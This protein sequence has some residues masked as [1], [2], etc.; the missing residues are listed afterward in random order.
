MTLL[1]FMA[2]P[3][4]PTSLDADV[5][6]FLARIPA[7]NDR[8]GCF[9]LWFAFEQT[10]PEPVSPEEFDDAARKTGRTVEVYGRLYL[11]GVD[12]QAARRVF[13]ES[14]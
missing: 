13:M 10:H 8:V 5:A 7:G 6:A 4:Q 9:H 14:F 12:A 1:P 11:N 2:D 3:V